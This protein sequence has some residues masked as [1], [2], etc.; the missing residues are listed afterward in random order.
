MEIR[1]REVIERR[2]AME[3]ELEAALIAKAE[4]RERLMAIQEQQTLEQR[5]ALEAELM[6]LEGKEQLY[7]EMLSRTPEQERA[8]MQAEAPEAFLLSEAVPF[9]LLDGRKATL[10]EEE[11]IDLMM[12]IASTDPDNEV[13]KAAIRSIGRLGSE[14][15]AEALVQLYDSQDDIGLKKTVLSSLGWSR[16][17]NT[18]ILNK[19]KNIAGSDPNPELRKAALLGLAGLPGDDGVSALISI[20]D[21]TQEK[22]LKKFIIRYLSQGRSDEA[23]EKLK[24]IARS[25]ADAS[26]RLEAVRSLGSVHRGPMIG[27]ADAPVFAEP[28]LHAMPMPVPAP[29]PPETPKPPEPPK[30]KKN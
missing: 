26:L 4:E 18:R 28:Y 5:R 10:P 1:E 20:Y 14:A 7:R 30:K 19:L 8:L 29:D 23:L 24:D 25:D 6:A 13:R 15:A 27:Y 2:L 3:A 21:Q 12:D 17:S 11:L 16:M 22:D 9:P